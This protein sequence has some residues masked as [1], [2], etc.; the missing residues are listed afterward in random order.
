[1]S[2]RFTATA[3]QLVADLDRRRV[4]MHFLTEDDITVVLSCRENSIFRIA[5][6][7]EQ[8]RRDCPEILKWKRRSLAPLLA[9]PAPRSAGGATKEY[10]R[11]WFWPGPLPFGVAAIFAAALLVAGIAV[12]E[13]SPEIQRFA[14]ETWAKK[15]CPN[16]T[17]VWLSVRA[18]TFSQSDERWYGLTKDGAFVCKRDAEKAGYRASAR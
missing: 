6:S 7:I 16:D 12:A 17:V 18:R 5:E 8:L 9:T 14:F 15:H 3:V 13:P 10:R 11:R 4:E 1:M 2:V